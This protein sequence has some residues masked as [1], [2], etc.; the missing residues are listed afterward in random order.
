MTGETTPFLQ[1]HTGKGHLGHVRIS[2]LCLQCPREQPGP[3]SSATVT[4]GVQTMARAETEKGEVGTVHLELR[5]PGTVF[6]KHS[7]QTTQQ[8]PNMA[9]VQNRAHM[10]CRMRAAENQG[11]YNHFSSPSPLPAQLTWNS[12]P[13][14]SRSAVKGRGCPAC[15]RSWGPFPD[16]CCRKEFDYYHGHK[17]RRTE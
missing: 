7:F 6:C 16:P 17:E 10:R 12:L 8:L 4:Q 5:Y 1:P 2:M 13:R 9:L 3:I 11:G 14:G 15:T